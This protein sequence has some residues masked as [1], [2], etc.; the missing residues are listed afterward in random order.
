M[1]VFTRKE[2]ENVLV[3]RIVHNTHINT[4]LT[5][6]LRQNLPA[7]RCFCFSLPLSIPS[8]LGCFP[9]LTVFEIEWNNWYFKKYINQLIRSA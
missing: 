8:A 7:K 9:M 3:S 1:K 6:R 4:Y 5:F 2:N